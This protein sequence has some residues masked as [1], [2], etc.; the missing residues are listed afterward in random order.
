MPSCRAQRS[1][2][3]RVRTPSIP[4][5][6]PQGLSA[7]GGCRGVATQAHQG[8]ARIWSKI[9]LSAY[10]GLDLLNRYRDLFL[11]LINNQS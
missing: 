6:D 1:G 2:L 8:Q 10:S 11:S 5:Q 3:S 7:D 9:D 4:L